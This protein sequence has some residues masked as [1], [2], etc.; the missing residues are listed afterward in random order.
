MVSWYLFSI[1][2]CIFPSTS[3][4]IYMYCVSWYTCNYALEFMICFEAWAKLSQQWLVCA[5]LGIH[6][7][8][9]NKELMLLVIII[10]FIIN[11]TLW[12]KE[13]TA[14]CQIRSSL[15]QLCIRACQNHCYAYCK[16][17]IYIVEGCIFYYQ[18]LFNSLIIPSF[19][20]LCP[21]Q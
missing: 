1:D 11:C 4:A 2:T 7:E 19:L 18:T 6:L 16:F 5:P 10:I 13:R 8:P 9:I 3:A 14:E 21:Q 20:A 15:G 12:P 17:V